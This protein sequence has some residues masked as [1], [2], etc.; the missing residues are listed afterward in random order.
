MGAGRGG[1]GVTCPPPTFILILTTE[2]PT[3]RGF[4]PLEFKWCPW[5]TL[6]TFLA[7]PVGTWALTKIVKLKTACSV[8]KRDM[9]V[10]MVN[11]GA[12]C[13]LYWTTENSTGL[14]ASLCQRPW[15]GSKKT[16]R[17]DCENIVLSLEDI[18]V[19][20]ETAIPIRLLIQVL[21]LITIENMNKAEKLALSFCF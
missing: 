2:R 4:D 1:K 18:I 16:S 10:W 9:D 8:S 19:L 3:F 13:R 5:H 11:I 20:H 15:P 7:A 21:N 6:K 17:I 12:F 14:L